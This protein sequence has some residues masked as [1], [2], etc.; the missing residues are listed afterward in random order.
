VGPDDVNG[1]GEE[2]VRV[3]DDRADVE[4]VLPVLDR[5]VEAVAACVEVVD[6]RLDGPVAVA[7][8]DV[9]AVA[10]GKEF[11]VQSSVVG[12]REGMWPD[13]DRYIGLTGRRDVSGR[14]SRCRPRLL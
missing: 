2:R 9:A 8:D 10:I 3:A 7:V 14:A 5:N 6:D 11:G 1:A 12:P 4:V 13:T